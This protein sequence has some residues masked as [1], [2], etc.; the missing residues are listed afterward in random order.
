MM[1]LEPP[2]AVLTPNWSLFMWKPGNCVKY[3]NYQFTSHA[4]WLNLLLRSQC[5]HLL[6]NPQ[7]F[8][9]LDL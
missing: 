8:C 3:M 7:K 1:K 4:T 5:Q 2:E 9:F 6:P